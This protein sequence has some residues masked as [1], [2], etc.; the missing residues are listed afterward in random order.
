MTHLEINGSKDGGPLTF[1]DAIFDTAPGGLACYGS[2]P[3]AIV[4][5]A[6]FE[7][8]GSH[9]VD[10]GTTLDIDFSGFE[11]GMKLVFTVDVDQ[12][13]FVDPQ[14]G[15][16]EVDAVDEGAEFQRSHFVADFTAP[17]DYDLTTSTQFWDSYDQNFTTAEQQGDATLDL[18]PDR[19]T[20]PA[21]DQSVLTAGAVSVATQQPLPN[22]IA[23]TVFYDRNLDNAQD[24]D[25]TGIAGVTLTLEAF[26][27]NAYTPTG[28]TA[29]TDAEGYYHFDAL[30]P[31][32]FQVV[33][34]QPS[35]YFGVGAEAG[36]VDGQT[37]GTVASSDVLTDI[38][39]LGGEDSVENDFA[40]AL[41]ASLAGHVG[42]DNVGGQKANSTLPPIAGV[43][44]ELLDEAGDTVATT[45]TDNGGNY[46]FTN[47]MPGNYG[48]REVQ[49]GTYFDGDTEAGSAGGIVADDLVTDIAL[50]SGVAA[51]DYD[52]SEF[53]P[54][55]ISGHV[56][57]DM[58]V[59]RRPPPTCLRSRMSRFNCSTRRA[60]R[61]PRRQPI[62]GAIMRSPTS[63]RARMGC[64][65]FHRAGI[66][67]ATPR[68][69]RKA[70]RRPRG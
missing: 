25:E 65:R 3:L 31:G 21:N 40:E 58:I 64:A 44:I 32:Q 49:P 66:S 55:G 14:P 57:I 33:E 53:S 36:T 16:V 47:L 38:A 27:G 60:T 7:I 50:A 22:S 54:A 10:G 34:T 52:F 15:D 30:P 48:V 69:A 70:A 59:G 12:V 67:T 61:S 13:L 8:T 68:P 5:H 37:R 41:P 29:V 43:T 35:G 19:Y 4:S 28:A 24:G 56:G 6:G 46:R 18:P 23:G 63:R 26:N 11:A 2:S 45:T 1:N 17:H 62:R 39:L 42:L 20:D 9:V 51:T